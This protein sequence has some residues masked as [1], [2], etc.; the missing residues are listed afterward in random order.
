MI[1]RVMGVLAVL[2]VIGACAGAEEPAAETDMAA[3]PAAEQVSADADLAASSCR[4]ETRMP[5]E[6]RPSPYDSVTVDLNGAEAKVCYG[7][8]SARERE[9][10]GGLVPYD[11]LW[12]TGANEPTTI[13]LPVAAEIAGMRVEPGSY[14]IY[15]VP[16]RQQWTVIVNRSTAQWGIESQYTDAIRA[17][18]VGRAPVPAETLPEHVETFTIGTEATGAGAA[19]LVLSWERTRVKIPIRRV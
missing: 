1:V 10:F 13:H 11:T 7:R 6:G 4:P 8:P 19:N 12:R 2:G 17:Q 14:T 3:A 9:V 15:T 16:G 18:E 5:L